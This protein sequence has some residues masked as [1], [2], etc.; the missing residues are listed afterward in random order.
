MGEYFESSSQS[1]FRSNLGS[2]VVSRGRPLCISFVTSG[3]GSRTLPVPVGPLGGCRPW[4]GF[5][6][7]RPRPGSRLRSRWLGSGPRARLFARRPRPRLGLGARFLSRG[8]RLGTRLLPGSLRLGL[9]SAPI[10]RRPGLGPGARLPSGMLRPRPRS[11][12]RPGLGAGPGVGSVSA[13][14]VSGPRSASG[15]GPGVVGVLHQLELSTVKVVAVV[16]FDRALHVLPAFEL[17]HPR[18]KLFKSHY[19]GEVAGTPDSSWYP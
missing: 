7:R 15:T 13:A 5:L 6:S 2:V 17:D 8:P 4:T 11:G 14:T 9:G 10:S 18:K 1:S 12:P 3:S 19:L 16:L